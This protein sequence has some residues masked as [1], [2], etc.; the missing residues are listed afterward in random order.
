ML[1]NSKLE[2]PKMINF[3]AID[4]NF[5]GVATLRV[6]FF[7]QSF[8]GFLLAYC[9]SFSVPRVPSNFFHSVFLYFSVVFG[10]F[11]PNES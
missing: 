10:E 11:L 8:E 5:F 3:V 4:S 2:L 9:K 7:F 6:F 1:T